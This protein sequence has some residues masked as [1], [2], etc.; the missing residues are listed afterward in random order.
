MRVGYVNKSFDKITQILT[1]FQINITAS[2]NFITVPASTNTTMV[3]PIFYQV[4]TTKYTFAVGQPIT[5]F[6]FTTVSHPTKGVSAQTYKLSYTALVKSITGVVSQ[7]TFVVVQKKTLLNGR[8]TEQLQSTFAVPLKVISITIEQTGTSVVSIIRLPKFYVPNQYA[9]VEEVATL[10]NSAQVLADNSNPSAA[11]VINDGSVPT[12]G[13]GAWCIVGITAGVLMVV[14][15]VS[16]AAVFMI[17][18]IKKRT[19]GDIAEMHDYNTDHAQVPYTPL[20]SN[21]TIEQHQ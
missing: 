13:C 14:V 16:A 2:S 8:V 9:L 6:T 20:G 19:S 12:S 10:E 17:A 18:G 1:V 3:V 4:R 11:A 21:A 7:Q 15:A 5:H